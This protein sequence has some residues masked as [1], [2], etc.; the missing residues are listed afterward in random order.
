[1]KLVD[2][3]ESK[4]SI[5]L[6]HY[7][8]DDRP[9]RKFNPLPISEFDCEECG[10]LNF[11]YEDTKEIKCIEC[12]KC[13]KE[14]PFDAIHVENNIAVIDYEKCKNCGKCVKACPMN[15]IVNLRKERKARK[16]DA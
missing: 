16:K 6:G 7:F 4:L 2:Y 14:C 5:P 15:V 11:V 1:M 9:K 3:I 8:L 13:E 10:E 12:G